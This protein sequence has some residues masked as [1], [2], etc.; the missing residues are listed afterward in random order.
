MISGTITDIISETFTEIEGIN[1]ATKKDSAI[2]TKTEKTVT[3]NTVFFMPTF[4]MKCF[5]RRLF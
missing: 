4:K 3:N 5:I 1:V 2:D